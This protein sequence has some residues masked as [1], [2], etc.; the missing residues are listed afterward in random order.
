MKLFPVWEDRLWYEGVQ[1]GMKIL[2]SESGDR[3]WYRTT[4]SSILQGFAFWQLVALDQ[5]LLHGMRHSV[6][7]ACCMLHGVFDL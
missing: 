7:V 4:R 6:D 3:P 2:P 5:R 1:C